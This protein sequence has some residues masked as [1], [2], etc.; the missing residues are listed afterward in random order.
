MVTLSVITPTIG[1][2]SLR[3][4]L[5]RLLP[6]LGEGD[7]VL[8]IGDGPQPHAKAIADKLASPYVR[9]WEHGPIMNYGNPQRN[10][11]IAEAKG[12]YIHFVDD[13]DMPA[14]DAVKNI[15]K[16]AAEA[17]GKPIMFRMMHCGTPLWQ[18]PAVICAN[19]SGQM[20]V[21]PNVKDRIGKWSGRY[22][23][24][25]DF[26]KS[27]LALYPGKDA[28]VVWRKEIICVQGYVG[29]QAIAKEIKD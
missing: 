2:E 29:R 24:D 6:Q 21:I 13:D 14:K 22:E 9:Y 20:F 1:R 5:E 16:A 8:V 17:P 28:D 23:A 25:F 18:A 19:V 15:K 3:L 27:T 10:L 7:E 26:M 11:A 12:D 4:M